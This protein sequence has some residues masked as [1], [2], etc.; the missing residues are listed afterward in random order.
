[1]NYL[2]GETQ[3]SNE[4]QNSIKI[5]ESS[6]QNGMDSIINNYINSISN[7][8]N[9]MT[10]LATNHPALGQEQVNVV[11][12][13]TPNLDNIKNTASSYLSTLQDLRNAIVSGTME[14]TYEGAISSGYNLYTLY[15]TL[16]NTFYT[17]IHSDFNIWLN[18]LNTENYNIA[19]SEYD[20]YFNGTN[21]QSNKLQNNTITRLNYEIKK[22]KSITQL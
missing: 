13:G 2:Y 5:F 17:E 1:M 21:Q 10:V 3:Q 19:I 18:I 22:R 12:T 11:T 7:W 9:F 8:I 6:I 4:I 16:G 15:Y 20:S 14:Y